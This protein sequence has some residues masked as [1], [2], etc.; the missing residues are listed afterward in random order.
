MNLDELSSY[1]SIFPKNFNHTPVA[2]NKNFYI[3]CLTTDQY[4]IFIAFIV[5]FL[6]AFLIFNLSMSFAGNPKSQTACVPIKI[7]R[8]PHGKKNESD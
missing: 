4:A 7:L 8:V 3:Y 6:T 2:F 1:N 5:I